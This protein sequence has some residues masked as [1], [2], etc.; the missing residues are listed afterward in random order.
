MA[1]R[2][3]ENTCP[4][5]CVSAAAGLDGEAG[6]PVAVVS[7][8]GRRAGLEFVEKV[9][10]TNLISTDTTARNAGMLRVL[11]RGITWS[12]WLP[13][14]GWASPRCSHIRAQQPL[15]GPRYPDPAPRTGR[16]SPHPQPGPGKVTQQHLRTDKPAHRS[17][18]QGPHRIVRHRQPGKELPDQFG[19]G[20]VQLAVVAQLHRGRHKS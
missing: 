13:G 7:L 18:R 17:P 2:P 6:T 12:S 15:A 8:P 11:H 3:G 16:A 20:W 5:G 10:T 9:L 4:S 1:P 14:S 19:R